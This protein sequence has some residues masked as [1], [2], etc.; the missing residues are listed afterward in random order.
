MKMKRIEAALK[1]VFNTVKVENRKKKISNALNSARTNFE[2]DKIT[3][4]ENI[5][6]CIKELAECP[7]IQDKISDINEY[8]EKKEAAEMGIKRI[9]KIE[10][11]LNEEVEVEEKK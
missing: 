1:G 11:Y 2:D 5:D 7:N 9:D 8:I 3:A 4:E 10:K 6:E